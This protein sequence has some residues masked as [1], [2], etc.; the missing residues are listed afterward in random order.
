MPVC[1]VKVLKPTMDCPNCTADA[2]EGQ[3]GFEEDESYYNGQLYDDDCGLPECVEDLSVFNDG[4]KCEADKEGFM[5]FHHNLCSPE[6]SDT[7]KFPA[8]LGNLDNCGTFDI[9]EP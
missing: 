8:N 6:C 5:N 7:G 4:D 1:D 2:V 3:D 9:Y